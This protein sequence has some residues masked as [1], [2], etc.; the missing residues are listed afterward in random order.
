M[1]KSANSRSYAASRFDS[2]WARTA[3]RSDIQASQTQIFRLLSSYGP[4]QHSSSGRVARLSAH[5]K[6]TRL[7][8]RAET[9]MFESQ[10]ARDSFLAP[11]A[12]PKCGSAFQAAS[13]CQPC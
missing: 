3:S 12:E 7:G 6:Q 5:V 2:M 13:M 4:A 10:R 1:R 11:S 9:D 8:A